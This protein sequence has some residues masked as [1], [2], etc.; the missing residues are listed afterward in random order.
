MFNI[1]NYYDYYKYCN[2]TNNETNNKINN[3]TNSKDCLISVVIPMYNS[4]KTLMRCLSSIL[5]QTYINDIEIILVDDCSNEHSF[6]ECVY[7]IDFFKD[8]LNLEVVQSF[9]NHGAGY[10]R[11]VGLDRCRGKYVTFLDSDDAFLTPISIEMMYLPFVENDKK[12][13]YTS[14]GLVKEDYFKDMETNKNN[15]NMKK[16]IYTIEANNT[17]VFGKMFDVEFLNRNNIKFNSER[18][19]EDVYFNLLC[20]YYS[21]SRYTSNEPMVFWSKNIESVTNTKEFEIDGMNEI[22]RAHV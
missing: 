22:G 7:I 18:Y 5:M 4:E 8:K 10:A 14:F 15:D 21:D 1:I 9:E 11:Q 2:E 19:N 13:D 3:D 20:S 16:Y 17:W 6:I 12:Y